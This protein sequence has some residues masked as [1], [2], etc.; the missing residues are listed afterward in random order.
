MGTAHGLNLLRDGRV[1]KVFNKQ[2]GLP[3]DDVRA[4]RL[5]SAGV[6]WVGTAAGIALFKD[7]KFTV[8]AGA[9][10]NPIAALGV[11]REGRTLFST[12]HG[13][14]RMEGDKIREIEPDGVALRSVDAIYRDPDGLVWLGTN[15]QGL[16]LLDERGARPKALSS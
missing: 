7:G 12:E 11:D 16:R 6:L 9:P 8:P 13:L 4:L 10:A 3:S 15:G 14:F 5:D 2:F 1:V